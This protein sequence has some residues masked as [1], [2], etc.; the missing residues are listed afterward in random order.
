MTIETSTPIVWFVRHGIILTLCL[1]AACR[2]S[3]VAGT[4]NCP[5]PVTDAGSTGSVSIPWATGFE[6]LFCDYPKVSG[7]CYDQGAASHQ[8]VTSPVHSG[9]YAAAFM[10]TADTASGSMGQVRCV[11]QGALPVEAYYGAWYYFPEAAN[12]TG[13]WNLFHFQGGDAS[14][15]HGL[16]DV[17]L[18]N[19]LDGKLNLRVYDFLHTNSGDGPA[20]PIG[21]WTHIVFYLKRAADQT[22]EVALYQDGAQVVHFANLNTDD[23]DWGQWYM[24]N[25]VTAL[26]PP[27]STV[28]VDDVTIAASQ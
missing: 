27:D 23:T 2:P 24:G 17:S 14:S 20:V 26:Q 13:V 6:E 18:L 7:F 25:L 11:R 16:W 1:L 4:W 8:I 5:G 28:Y 15:Q 9:H 22:G 19:G 21:S 12:N 3:L 10:A